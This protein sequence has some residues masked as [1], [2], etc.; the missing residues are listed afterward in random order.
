MSQH[1]P[2]T[3]LEL[4]ERAVSANPSRDLL[5]F[6]DHRL[7]YSA[8]HQRVLLARRALIGMGVH[9]GDNVGVLMQNCPDHLALMF[10]ISSLGAVDVPINTRNRPS[11]LA[12][13]VEDA[14]LRLIFT[15]TLGSD[16]SDLPARLAEA[17]AL[18]GGRIEP[19]IVLLDGAPTAGLQASA[20]VLAAASGVTEEQ[21]E[22][23]AAETTG[24]DAAVMLYTSGT[25]ANPKGCPLLHRQLL[26]ISGQV[27][28]RWGT[29]EGDKVWNALP[30]FHASSI[31]PLLAC[32]RV[33]GTFISATVF[34][35]EE[36]IR[37]IREEGATLAW[38]AFGTVWQEILT[39]PTFTAESV[40]TV[41]AIIA[42][43]PP[44][45]VHT[46]ERS[47]PNVAILSCYGITEGLGVPV[48]VR[49]DDDPVI[50]T[51]TSGLPF[52]GIEVEVRDPE[53]RE[54]LPW[55]ERGA[56]WLRGE[57]VFGGYWN[58]PQ[59]TAEAFD[60]EGW[61]NTGDLASQEESGVV[62][63]HGRLKD[64]L[65]VGG[66]NVAAV[67]IEAYLST[68]PAVKLAAVVGAPDRKYGEVPAAFIE[69]RPGA[70]ATAEEL[71]EYCRAGIA[72]FKV[73]RYLRFVT[74]WPMSATKIR[75]VDLQRELAEE[76]SVGA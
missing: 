1:H 63:Y 51:E 66:E 35:P 34:E 11:E 74:E 68:H 24:D 25:T 67:E 54:R 70:T 22:A 62:S 72:G 13:V 32:I 75:K 46:M 52:D 2:R 40:Q 8:F 12:H 17:I 44:E 38:P 60:D 19:R 16:V 10:A 7:S 73:P 65:K 56:L 47:A 57:N 4:L 3:L 27:G 30:Y 49:Y 48:M 5:V 29:R 21:A 50:R 55:G 6:P 37:M 18:L 42:V 23:L 36:T 26:S 15:S 69:L 28:E 9:R 64:M 45:T 76:L 59:H 14:G 58:D 31:L 61:F 41:R 43:A 39:H 20:E 71:I 53:T 33:N